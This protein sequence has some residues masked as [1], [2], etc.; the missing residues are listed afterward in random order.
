MIDYKANIEAISELNEVEKEF[1]KK[2][3]C[4]AKQD[5]KR[6]YKAQSKEYKKWYKWLK[7][8]DYLIYKIE[9]YNN[10][11]LI[12]N[13]K[14]AFEF[15]LNECVD[16]VY[17]SKQNKNAKA[18]LQALTLISKI[19]GLETYAQ[20][21]ITKLEQ[22]KRQ[23]DIKKLTTEQLRQLAQSVSD[24]IRLIN[25]KAS[26]DDIDNTDDNS[27]SDSVNSEVLSI[28]EATGTAFLKAD[29]VKNSVVVEN[30][31]N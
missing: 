29:V 25:C 10:L 30:V 3:F 21:T 8:H 14:Q 17:S 5:L 15:V 16:L 4:I 6:L 22:D 7:K 12:R 1:L 23:A 9:H 20:T 24:N 11:A 18:E 19:C 26:N 27:L 31:E 2:Y 13:S 28:P